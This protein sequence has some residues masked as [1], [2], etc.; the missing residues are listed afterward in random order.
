MDYDFFLISP[1]NDSAA[2]KSA[3]EYFFSSEKLDFTIAEE[4]NHDYYNCFVYHLNLDE[5]KVQIVK[6]RLVSK[7]Q[8]NSKSDGVIL[9]RDYFKGNAGFIAFDMDS[10]LIECEC[11]DELAVKAGVGDQVKEVTAAAM[12]GELDFSGSFVKRLS[13]LEGLGLEALD[14]LKDELPLMPGMESLVN[15]LVA[16]PWKT[17]VFSG[18][19]TYFADSLQE[20]F[21]FDY[22][23]AN[24]LECGPDALTGKHI[25]GIVD[26][27][28]KKASLLELTEK[29]GVDPKFTVAVGD[30]ANDLPMIHASGQGFAFHAKPIVCAE[31]PNSVKNCDLSALEFILHLI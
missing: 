3:V 18:G 20:R 19:F 25:G 8:A 6:E 26:S 16:S 23:R 13:L 1:F 24:V 22:V 11:I 28:V 2:S 12:R 31:A 29:E 9:P 14:E 17:A 21:G 10:T 5:A 15:K 7:L 30:G 27:Q 4:K